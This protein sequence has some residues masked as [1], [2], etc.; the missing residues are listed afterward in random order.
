MALPFGFNAVLHTSTWVPYTFATFECVGI[1][2]DFAK[3]ERPAK[4]ASHSSQKR[5]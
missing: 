5:G 4:I 3:V 1:A 2:V